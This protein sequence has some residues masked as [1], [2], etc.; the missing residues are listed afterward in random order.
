M[1]SKKTP[2]PRG[3]IPF[4]PAPAK[5]APTV[6]AIPESTGALATGNA[7]ELLKQHALKGRQQLA[8]MPASA[9]SAG[10]SFRGGTISVGDDVVGHEMRVVVLHPQY[11]RTYYAR[12]YEAGN[13]SPPDCYSF[14]G[15][16]PHE[17]SAAI[18][19]PQCEGCP[20]NEW[21]SDRRQRGKACKEG[22]RLG[23][24]RF[25]GLT[26]DNVATAPILTARLSVMNA[27]DAQPVLSR[28]YD[29]IGHPAGA[30]TTLVAE[31]DPV[32]QIK[33]ELV[34]EGPLPEE[35]QAGVIARLEEAE[36]LLTTPYPDPEP[37]GAF[38][39]RKAA[40]TRRKF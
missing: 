27:K 15:V 19:S 11:E 40:S 24:L 16:T 25:D 39:A 4:P 32:R 9:G 31:S 10:V 5:S 18:Q 30:I 37:D 8:K 33:N 1:P 13:K 6:P 12:D 34:P 2:S 35:L 23:M 3:D 21:K 38:P 17:K 29:T 36:K 7:L 20:W 14:D 26:P 28:M 22:M